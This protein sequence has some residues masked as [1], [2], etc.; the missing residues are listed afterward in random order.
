MF[1]KSRF[2]KVIKDFGFQKNSKDIVY[3][4]K[5]GYSNIFC[6]EPKLIRAL[7]GSDEEYFLY[8]TMKNK[9]FDVLINR[10]GCYNKR[11]LKKFDDYKTIEF[12]NNYFR[13]EEVETALDKLK[14][15]GFAKLSFEKNIF[16]KNGKQYSVEHYKN[17][18]VTLTSSLLSGDLTYI[19]KDDEPVGY[20]LTKYFNTNDM[21]R[22]CNIDDDLLGIL[23]KDYSMFNNIAVVDYS[24]ISEKYRGVGLGKEAYKLVID[25]FLKRGF[26][27]RASTIQSK[28]AKGLWG[29][30]I[31][32]YGE[33]VKEE[34][35]FGE[36]VLLIKNN[37]ERL[38]RKKCLKM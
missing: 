1:Y 35:Y 4:L 2:E 36:K 10:D 20:I 7:K 34:K 19:K 3:A 6:N 11:I 17:A 31:K 24:N 16:D 14:E 9:D 5:N 38:R 25:D 29:A 37:E 30:I 12:D 27:F 18:D 13:E 28:D 26:D 22:N 8:S 21:K 15:I 32:D 33:S 23:K